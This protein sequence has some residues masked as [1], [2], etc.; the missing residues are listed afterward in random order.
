MTPIIGGK[1]T[2]GPSIKIDDMRQ[3]CCEACGGIFFKQVVSLC[4]IPKLLIGAPQDVLQAIPVFRCDDCGQLAEQFLP[5]GFDRMSK[6]S[7]TDS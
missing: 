3:T 4:I 7:P 6:I 5:E 2:Q 1:Q